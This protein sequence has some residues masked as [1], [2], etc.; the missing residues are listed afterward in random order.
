VTNDCAT[1]FEI[2]KLAHVNKHIT[3]SVQPKLLAKIGK[4]G[5]QNV[6]MVYSNA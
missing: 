6:P 2:C 1:P 4:V 5:V 3:S